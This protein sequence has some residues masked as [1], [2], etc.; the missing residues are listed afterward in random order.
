MHEFTVKDS[1]KPP[2]IKGTIKFPW[3]CLWFCFLMKSL[4]PYFTIVYGKS[5]DLTRYWV[6]QVQVSL[7]LWTKNFLIAAYHEICVQVVG[8]SDTGKCL[9]DEVTAWLR[10]KSPASWIVSFWVIG[11]ILKYYWWFSGKVAGLWCLQWKHSL[12]WQLVLS[13]FWFV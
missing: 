5:Y 12:C 8:C 6:L 13:C 10:K 4:L 3:F 7:L 11:E 2:H 1:V 9:Q